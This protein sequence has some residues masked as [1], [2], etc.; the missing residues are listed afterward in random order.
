MYREDWTIIVQLWNHLCYAAELRFANCAV[1]DFIIA[2]ICSRCRRLLIFADRRPGC[3]CC[4]DAIQRGVIGICNLAAACGIGVDLIAVAEYRMLI[5]PDCL[6]IGF[7]KKIGH[8]AACESLCRLFACLF[9]CCR[10]QIVA[11]LTVGLGVFID[12]DQR[13]TVLSAGDSADIVAICKLALFIAV[14]SHD[15]AGKVL[16]RRYAA[17]VI[18]V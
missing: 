18:A 7:A 16:A 2:S 4:S 3:V 17:G 14:I 12:I 11:V 10:H 13:C 5:C 6:S 9:R 1:N 15:A 8:F